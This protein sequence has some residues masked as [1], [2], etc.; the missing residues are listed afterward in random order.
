M[1]FAQGLEIG[2][3]SGTD[4]DGAGFRF[5]GK[6]CSARD[7]LGDRR[8]FDTGAVLEDEDAGE[9]EGIGARIRVR[10]STTVP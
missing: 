6:G 2:G 1:L 3:S 10:T 5:L 8:G 9:V 4:L 7:E